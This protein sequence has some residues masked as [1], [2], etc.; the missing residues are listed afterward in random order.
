MNHNL[1]QYNV[2]Y[3]DQEESEL[4]SII[5]ANSGAH[6]LTHDKII[7]SPLNKKMEI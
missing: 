4:N 1:W 6:L 5:N 2:Q 3:H 7:Q